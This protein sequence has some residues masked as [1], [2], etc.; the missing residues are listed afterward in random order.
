MSDNPFKA[1]DGAAR[2]SG[3]GFRR[4]FTIAFV[5]FAVV[6]AVCLGAVFYSFSAQEVPPTTG[7]YFSEASK[8]V[9][10]PNASPLAN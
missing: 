3:T 8:T 4:S 7:G 10:E 5:L 1:P 9:A 2:S 6:L